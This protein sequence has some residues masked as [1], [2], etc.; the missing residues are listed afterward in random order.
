MVGS[1]HQ[2]AGRGRRGRVWRD[3]PA[4]GLTVSILLR[5]EVAPPAAAMIPLV[6]ALAV[7]G[8]AEGLGCGD[9]TIAWPNDVLIDGRKVAGIL[10]ELAGHRD[11]VHHVVVGIGVNVGLTPDVPDARW[12]PCCL[13][14]H[15]PGVTRQQ[16]LIELLNSLSDAYARWRVDGAAATVDAFSR[17]DGLRGR[18]ISVDVGNRMVMGIGAGIDAEG[19]LRIETETGVQSFAS[20]EVVRVGDELGL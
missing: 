19:R 18:R 12:S 6:A 4:R 15:V 10:C 17:N 13:A 1:D 3:E 16:A 7:V 2:H 9:V 14:D 11:R 5:P 8:M 20:G